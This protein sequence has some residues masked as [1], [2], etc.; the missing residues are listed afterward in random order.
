[1]CSQIRV[2]FP[3]PEC[4]C[5]ATWAVTTTLNFLIAVCRPRMIKQVYFHTI[6]TDFQRCD[7][8]GHVW[9]HNK[10]KTKSNIHWKRKRVKWTKEKRKQGHVKKTRGRPAVCSLQVDGL[11]QSRDRKKF[12]AGGPAHYDIL[13]QPGAAYQLQF[14]RRYSLPPSVS[15]CL[16]LSYIWQL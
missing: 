3:H 15:L 12:P 6:I 10:Y 11:R 1:M 14:S 16:S 4:V 13:L 2:G 5:T 9:I 8:K 7:S